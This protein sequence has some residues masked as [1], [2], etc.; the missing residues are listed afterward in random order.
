MS[1]ENA[2]TSRPADQ[3]SSRLAR[4]TS[5]AQM[6]LRVED[7][8]WPTHFGGLAVVEGRALSDASGQLRLGEIRDRLDRRLVRVPQLRRR[9]YVPGPLRGRPLWVDDGRFA[10]EHHVQQATVESP[11]GDAEVLEAA[12][13]LYARLLDARG[14]SGNCGS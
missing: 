7:P 4:L 14:R 8:A 9:V 5:L 6:Y 11:G 13:R 3:G 12:A 2:K 1:I 10:I